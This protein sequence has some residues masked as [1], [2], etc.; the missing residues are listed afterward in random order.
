[1]ADE[2]ER[3][4]SDLGSEKTWAM[5]GDNEESRRR[6]SNF[7]RWNVSGGEELSVSDGP[8]VA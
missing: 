6:A 8:G 7:R 3:F 2:V 5:E 1:M 4:F